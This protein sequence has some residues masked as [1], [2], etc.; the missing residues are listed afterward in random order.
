MIELSVILVHYRTPELLANGLKSIYTH[1]G[2][3]SLEIIV[4][5]NS[6]EWDEMEQLRASFKEVNWIRA[7]YNLGFARA[8][9]LGLNK[10]TG[11]YF[12]LLNPDTEISSNTLSALIQTH[13]QKSQHYNVGLVTC[14]IHASNEQNLLVGSGRIFPDLK[15]IIRQ[16]P[17][18]IK[19]FRSSK[20]KKNY[21]PQ[22]MHYE[23]HEV[24][25]ASGAVVLGERENFVLSELKLDED[26]FL[27]WED[28]EWCYRL[29]RKGMHHFFCGETQ[30]QHIN[31][32][33]TSTFSNLA[34]QLYV[35]EILY[36]YKRLS[37]AQ[38]YIYRL[39][40]KNTL[41]VD[42][43]LAKSPQEKARI[44][45]RRIIFSKISRM[46]NKSYQR[47]VSSGNEYLRYDS[48]ILSK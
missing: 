7:D 19:F 16:H 27:Y 48:E 31:A 30:I 42:F 4:V 22:S 21:D 12:L 32:A 9:N 20:T 25:F 24:D 44:S 39:I 26:F 1:A 23:T 8:N 34:A 40:V 13:I 29:Q 38:F 43:L 45:E 15:R 37:I 11:R 33:S 46:V 5:D 41:W 14:R 36:Y 35:S 6:P 2:S 10:A 47:K 28:M 3:L 18:W 17:L